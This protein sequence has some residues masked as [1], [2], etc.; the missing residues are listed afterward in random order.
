MHV[1]RQW[2]TAGESPSTF[3]NALLRAASSVGPGERGVAVLVVN[4]DDLAANRR[5]FTRE[6][7]DA[8]FANELARSCFTHFVV[9]LNK[10]DRLRERVPADQIE[11]VVAAEA[12][13]V[14]ELLER[15]L[16]GG[17]SAEIVRGSA[18]TGHGM[19]QLWGAILRGLGLTHLFEF[20]PPTG[21]QSSPQP[22][23]A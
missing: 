12:A 13:R 18:L 15:A 6:V 11:S 21:D 20:E 1:V 16:G 5:Y 8:L 17:Y 2:T 14:I 7:V 19:R 4:L 23:P 3:L 22:E 9:L 10:E